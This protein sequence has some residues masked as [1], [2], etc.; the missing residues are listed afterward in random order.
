MKNIASPLARVT[1]ANPEE[2]NIYLDQIWQRL[3][4]DVETREKLQDKDLDLTAIDDMD[5]TPFKAERDQAGN[6]AGFAEAVL[7][8]LT[9]AAG[10]DLIKKVLDAI[11]ERIVMPK[12]KNRYGE[13]NKP[14]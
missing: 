12:L 4:K 14:D 13:V 3:R 2:V 6:T 8:G 9:V 11:W 7:I 10:S 1:S 5:T